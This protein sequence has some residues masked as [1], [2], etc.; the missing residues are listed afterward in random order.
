MKGPPVVV[1]KSMH[2][3]VLGK[4]HEGHQGSTKMKLRAR[5]CVYWLNI[6]RDIESVVSQCATC[7]KHQRSQPKEELLP[8]ELPTRPWQ[9]LGTDLFHLEG[10][11]Y[12]II[13]DYYSKF[14]LVRRMPIECT[15]KAV[16]EAT[17]Q[18]FSEH[19]IPEKVVSH[20]GPHFASSAFKEFASNWNFTHVTSSPHFPQSNGFVERAIQTIKHTLAKATSCKQKINMALLCL[21]TTPIDSELSSPAELLC[22]RKFKSNLPL[23]IHN[24]SSRKEQ[25]YQRLQQRQDQ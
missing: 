18:I 19:G 9:I 13:A 24:T 12:L 23:V 21:R 11:E 17:Q 5:N 16:I 22:D 2:E 3:N 25:N 4:L 10:R 1:P 8:H 20:N 7:Q 14:P 6:N 15:S